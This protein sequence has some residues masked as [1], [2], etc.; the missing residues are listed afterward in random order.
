[1]RFAEIMAAVASGDTAFIAAPAENIPG[2]EVLSS[3]RQ[4]RDDE[5]AALRRIDSA[6]RVPWGPNLMSAV[7]LCTA[8]LMETWAHGLDCFAALGV[9][10]V[11]TDR[12]RHVCHITYRAIPHALMESGVSRPD[13]INDLV[14][15]VS[16]PGGAMWRFGRG[17]APNRINGTAAEF[18]RV[19]VRRMRLEDSALRA[20]GPLA[21]AALPHLKAYL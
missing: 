11:D 15:E 12:L 19:G 7:S 16:S 14:V 13:T 1:A 4:A 5:L 8:R 20:H 21:E 17:N 3:W 6:A 18:A 2:N 10:P 9:E